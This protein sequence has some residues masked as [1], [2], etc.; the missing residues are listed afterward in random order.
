MT[1]VQHLW[2]SIVHHA[3]VTLFCSCCSSEVKCQPALSGFVP[4]NSKTMTSVETEEQDLRLN[5][6][7]LK[8][9]MLSTDGQSETERTSEAKDL[10]HTS[11]IIAQ[12]GL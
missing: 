4:G 12:T 10:H 11:A 9:N 7:L 8:D 1:Q 2:I 3:T 6:C 5:A